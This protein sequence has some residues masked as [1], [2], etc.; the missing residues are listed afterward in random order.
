M[1]TEFKFGT[2]SVPCGKM[3]PWTI[4]TVKIDRG[5]A[6][7]F[8]LRAAQDGN[9]WACVHPGT[10][11]RLRHKDRGVVMSNTRM[12]IITNY[13]AYNKA[14]GRVLINGLGLGM[15]LEGILSKPDVKFVRVV[16]IDPDVIA[17]VGPHFAS[18]VR[19]GRL[20]IVMADAYDYRPEKGERFNYVWHDIWDFIGDD[21]LPL[22]AHLGR[23]YNKR[24][25][26][27]QGFWA[28][29]QIYANRR[30]CG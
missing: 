3:G 20:D 8:N 10:F 22:M 13:E 28:R 24:V 5:D 16:E 11:K 7:M 26:D 23:R 6:V 18:E 19:K 21:N 14:T 27:A 15:V 30:R 25:A 4:D 12:E 2:C 29:E 1:S 9:A 17:L